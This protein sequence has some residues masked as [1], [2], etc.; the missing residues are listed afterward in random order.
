VFNLPIAICAA[1]AGGRTGFQLAKFIETKN[2][3]PAELGQDMPTPT[4]TP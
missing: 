2:Q 3:N 1:L 4:E